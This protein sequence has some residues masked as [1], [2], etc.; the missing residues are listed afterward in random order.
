MN[1]VTIIAMAA[2]KVGISASLLV[3]ICTH[4]SGLKNINNEN[5][6]GSPSIGICQIKHESAKLLGFKGNRF[7]LENPKINALYAAKYLKM[8]FD[9]YNNDAC[10]AV[11]A[12]NSGTYF[13]NKKIPG[14]PKN[15]RYVQD[16]QNL[17]TDEE[18][19]ILLQCNTIETDIA[20]GF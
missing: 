3:A 5:D 6:K 2:K 15:F 19:S 13:E 16:V 9:R 10:K 18:T 8:Q 4:E 20:K 14:R 7:A 17:I 11:A 1:Y 12:Y